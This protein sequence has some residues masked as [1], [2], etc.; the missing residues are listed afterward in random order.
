MNTWTNWRNA[1]HWAI[2]HPMQEFRDAYGWVYRFSDS[3][4]VAE[5]QVKEG[6]DGWRPLG[7]MLPTGRIYIEVLK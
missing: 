7:T 6:T 5:F 3:D 2:E 1:T 4:K